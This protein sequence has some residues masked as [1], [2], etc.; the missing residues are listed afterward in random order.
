M[1]NG[2]KQLKSEV[3]IL[4]GKLGAEANANKKIKPSVSSKGKAGI[5]IG[6]DFSAEA[7]AMQLV[8][9]GVPLVSINNGA[10][11]V[12]KDTQ[13]NL[14]KQHASAKFDITGSKNSNTGIG[15]SAGVEFASAKSTVIEIKLPGTSNYLAIEVTENIGFS[16]TFNPIKYEDWKFV[17]EIGATLGIGGKVS[18]EFGNKDYSKDSIND[19]DFKKI[20]RK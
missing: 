17:S 11:E 10:V 9:N 14:F 13:F 15:F 3:D 8:Q 4:F 19:F 12:L 6:G 7:I 18:A 20:G 16:G 1:I 5:S 2:V